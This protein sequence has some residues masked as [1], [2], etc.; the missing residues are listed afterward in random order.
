MLSLNSKQQ[1]AFNLMAKGHNIFLTG[2]A[3]SGK[4]T[5][6]KLFKEKY[7]RVKRIAVTS[8]T[9]VSASLIN[10]CT[11]H[12]FAGI[13]LGKSDINVLIHK[14]QTNGKSKQNWKRTDVLIIDEVSMLDSVLLE[15]LECIART[16]RKSSKVFGGIQL[17]LSGDFFQLPCVNS[18]T[19]CFESEIWN[20]CIT[21][22]CYLTEI[23]RQ[24]DII[25][26]KVLNNV[27]INNITDETRK[28]LDS[29]VRIELK[30]NNG[31]TPTRIYSLKRDVKE[32]N[33]F[34]IRRIRNR[35]FVYDMVVQTFKHKEE[36]E[37]KTCIKNCPAEQT[38][39]L[40]MNAQVMLLN[41][42]SL[43]KFNGSRGVI[44]GFTDDSLPVVRFLDG[45]ELVI[46]SHTWSITN[47]DDETEVTL[48]QI[49]LKLAYALTIHKSQ[50][51]SLDYAEINLSD[52]FEFGQAYVALSRVKSLEGLNIIDID[53]NRIQCS[54]VVKTYYDNNRTMY[55]KYVSYVFEHRYNVFLEEIVNSIIEYAVEW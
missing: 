1:R 48:T 8:T 6:I 36:Y 45:V 28:I 17:I 51:C 52:V 21:H 16:I 4:S 13:G 53:Y 42:N 20:R 37:I 31:I 41:N 39:T 10:G 55:K 26:Q 7:S 15:K 33:E 49:P 32:I 47:Q 12:S 23:V 14:V 50:G 40:C 43:N 30:N 19:Y 3:G 2:V 27:R 9:G 22:T 46:N 18:S 35:K 5:L 54:D 29:R 25:F 38:L 24:K 11:L 34:E 44:I